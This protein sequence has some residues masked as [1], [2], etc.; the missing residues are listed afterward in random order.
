ML[1]SEPHSQE[2]EVAILSAVLSDPKNYFIDCVNTLTED[3]FHN[4]GHHAI[5]SKLKEFMIK[6]P[7]SFD[8]NTFIAF[9]ENDSK[10]V[11]MDIFGLLDHIYSNGKR[12]GNTHI[13]HYCDILNDKKRL[14]T[15]I[16][17]CEEA[18][19][20]AKDNKDISDKVI[21]SLMIDHKEQTLS[22]DEV[23][24][25]WKNAQQGVNNNIPTPYPDLDRVTGGL[26]RG[27]V[28][29]FTGRS[30]SGK[31][32]FLASWYKYL[33]E[34]KIPI[35][36]L[37][38]EDRHEITIKRMAACHGNYTASEL[39]AGGRYVN[40]NNKWTWVKITDEEIKK[41]KES[42]DYV[43][44]LPIHFFDRKITAKQL[45]QIAFR[46]KNKYDIQAIFVD[47]A[48]DL[49]KRSGEYNDVS[50]DEET[51]Q[52]F[53]Q[54][55]AETNTA[56]VSVHHL[57]KISLEQMIDVNSVRGSSNII[58]DSRSVYCLQS[59]AMNDYIERLGYEIKY[60]EQGY[61]TTRIFECL[62]NNHGGTGCKILES[63]LAKCR[64]YEAKKIEDA[65]EL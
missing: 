17:V 60:N 3:H 23:Y 63:D 59:S 28:T 44:Q 20:A 31:S 36:V 7:S 12:Y 2:A 54:V 26:R 19:E 22:V 10:F 29:V 53:C 25:G 41:A 40:W 52:M 35:L 50:A 21:S 1:T 24:S 37:P 62:S 49:K 58:A 32:M 16:K 33:A 6:H 9:A 30:K 27:C 38:L 51:S 34:Q 5:F 48:K 4:Y 46:Y 42:L 43:S 15:I 11:E 55:A 14:R 8:M 18:T 47:G 45:R 65:I 13:E 61:T 57:T 56:L 64:F 39:D